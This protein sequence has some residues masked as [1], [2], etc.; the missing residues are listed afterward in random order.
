MLVEDIAADPTT[1]ASRIRVSTS[2]ITQS[3]RG[4]ALRDT[5]CFGDRDGKHFKSFKLHVSSNTKNN[6]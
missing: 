1:T 5:G 6:I 3:A 2:R 4:L